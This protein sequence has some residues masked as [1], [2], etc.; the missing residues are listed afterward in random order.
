[1]TLPRKRR[2][3]TSGG[4]LAGVQVC[5]LE[6]MPPDLASAS[7]EWNSRKN[8]LPK[9]PQDAFSVGVSAYH[10]YRKVGNRVS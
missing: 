4:K 10:A 9:L 1:M 8:R 5:G 3:P 2:T 6:D 7:A